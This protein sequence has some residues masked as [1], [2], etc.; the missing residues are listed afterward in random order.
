MLVGES[1][2]RPSALDRLIDVQDRLPLRL[3]CAPCLCPL[4]SRQVSFNANIVDWDD[5][6]SW[7]LQNRNEGCVKIRGPAEP[8]GGIGSYGRSI[9]GDGRNAP[10]QTR[11]AA[12]YASAV[13]RYAAAG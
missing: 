2:H 4:R 3:L 7:R 10:A 5:H 11:P 13:L 1:A 6:H 8:A 12:Q 9:C